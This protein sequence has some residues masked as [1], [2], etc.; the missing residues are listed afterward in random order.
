MTSNKNMSN[1]DVK[2]EFAEQLATGNCLILDL[3]VS[4][5]PA[6][7]SLFLAQKRET[8]SRSAANMNSVMS[9][10][11]GFDKQLNRAVINVE[12]AKVEALKLEIGNLFTIPGNKESNFSL[13][14][15]DSFKPSWADDTPITDKEGNER[16]KDGKAIYTHNTLVITSEL[17]DVIFQYDAE[18][19]E[20]EQT[21]EATTS[22]IFSDNPFK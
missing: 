14:V 11:S 9:F 15:N 6:Y 21:T 10:L 18:G 3:Q 17:K 19:A 13:Q 1:V 22:A 7:Y 4:K 2:K 12:A 16:K 8:A 20:E 5:N